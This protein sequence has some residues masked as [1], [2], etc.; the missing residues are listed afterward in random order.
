MANCKYEVYTEDQKVSPYKKSN[1]QI[2]LGNPIRI[3]DKIV[4]RM[5]SKWATT[6]IPADVPHL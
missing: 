5:L 2:V 1:A 3:Y 4:R 6:C